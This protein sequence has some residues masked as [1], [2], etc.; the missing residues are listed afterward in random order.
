[1]AQII[2]ELRKNRLHILGTSEYRLIGPGEFHAHT[3][4][5]ILHSGRNDGEHHSGAAMFLKKSIWRTL[6]GL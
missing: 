4:E 5:S 2:K 1:M 3:G 6:I